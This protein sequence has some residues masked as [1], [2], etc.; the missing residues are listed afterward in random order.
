MGL[1]KPIRSESNY[2]YYSGETLIRLKLIEGMKEKR[3]TLDE[4][5]E[6][7]GL[8]DNNPLE[9]DEEDKS[10]SINIDF[11]KEQ[12]KKLEDQLAQLQ[13]AVASLGSNQ[14]ALLTKK[15]LLQSMVLVQ[16]LMLYINEL[17]PEIAPFL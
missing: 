15:M 1:L 3:L 12:V 4:I 11:L 2:R 17:A 16:S 5:K 14:A 6:R 7:L 9:V 8:L 13:P 10:R